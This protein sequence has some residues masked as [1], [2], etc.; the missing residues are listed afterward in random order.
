M[1]QQEHVKQALAQAPEQ[2][3]LIALIQQSAQELGKA[4]P[5]HMNPER[6]VRIALTAIRL[7]PKLLQ[8][9]PESFLGSLF[10]LAQI[11]LEPIAGQ[12]YLLPF[13]NNRKMMVAGQEKWRTVMEVQALIGY[14]GMADLFYRNESSM[15]IDMQTVRKNDEFGYEYGTNAFLKHIPS[16]SERG[17]A[18]GYYAIATMKGGATKFHYMSKEQ[19]IAHGK[20]H[21]KVFDKKTGKFMPGTPWVDDVDAMCMKTVLIQLAKLLPRSIELQRAIAVDET[22]REY[23]KGI[24]SALDLPSTTN[25]EEPPTEALIEQKPEQKKQQAVK[26]AQKPEPQKQ[27]SAEPAPTSSI[28]KHIIEGIDKTRKKVG[29]DKFFKVLGNTG[30]ANIADI[31]NTKEATRLLNGLLKEVANGK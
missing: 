6:M 28:P 25:W 10:V 20:K 22:S 1:A 15:T 2:Q 3:N 11:G 24:S 17:E 23:R 13:R 29:E 26:P 31:P 30:Y 14:R 16:M 9:T 4:M 12:A 18:I 21:S 19:C 5:A 7:N 27:P 8:C